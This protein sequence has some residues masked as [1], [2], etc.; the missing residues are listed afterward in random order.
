MF[1]AR[2]SWTLVGGI[3]L[4]ALTSGLGTGVRGLLFGVGVAVFVW[5]N[6]PLVR[7]TFQARRAGHPG[8][9]PMAIG[10]ALRVIGLIAVIVVAW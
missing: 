5:L 8:W 7:W 2:L 10:F 3:G 4:L 6:E 9:Q 1:R